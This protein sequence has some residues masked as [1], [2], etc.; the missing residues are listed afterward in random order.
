M[1]KVSVYNSEGTITGDVE[2]NDAHF[3]VKVNPALVH[4][5]AVIQMANARRPIA[6]TKTRGEV[7]GGGKKP[8][9]QKGTG[10]ARHGSIRSP[11]WVGGGIT[12]GPRGNRNFSKKINRKARQKALFMA[13]SDK[14]AN[15]NL[16]IL[17]GF[18]PKEVKTK[19]LASC[20]ASLPAKR[21]VLFVTAASRPDVIRMARNLTDVYVTA[22]NSLNLVDTLRYGTVVF[23]KDAIPAFESL[24]KQS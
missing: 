24:Y 8:W 9:R 23:E 14:A 21:T 12:F 11:L 13:L 19:A 15:G 10:R 5:A 3:G 17:D 2:L 6:N 16:L 18:A 4:E 22:A 7:R 1:P 20:V